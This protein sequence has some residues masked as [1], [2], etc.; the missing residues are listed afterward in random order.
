[1]P[2]KRPSA[3]P[4]GPPRR[5]PAAPI[6]PRPRFN[7]S[8][9]LP[10]LLSGRA[11]HGPARHRP[12]P[13]GSARLGSAGLARLGT[14][15]LSTTP[16]LA[17][18]LAQRGAPGPAPRPV[19]PAGGDSAGRYRSTPT[20]PS[21]TPAISA[22]AAGSPPSLTAPAQFGS[23]RFRPVQFSSA[24]LGSGP[25]SPAR[26]LAARLGSE[27]YP[28]TSGRTPS[29]QRDPP[30]SLRGLRSHCPRSRHLPGS[31]R[32]GTACEHRA[33][34]TGLRP[35]ARPAPAP[36]WAGGPRLGTAGRAVSRRP[37]AASWRASSSGPG[38]EEPEPGGCT[39]DC[40]R[41]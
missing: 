16:H 31:A 39:P 10:Y 6:L 40:Q 15:R 11:R 37:S 5:T 20:D 8:L 3:R 30:R 1:M 27:R 29:P 17:A 35:P 7:R 32:P 9:L 13:P 24:R 36:R 14:V 28:G 34:S 2:S 38:P 19:P 12:A 41:D 25:R 4:L 22:A 23:A 18:Q 21:K 26:H 33:A